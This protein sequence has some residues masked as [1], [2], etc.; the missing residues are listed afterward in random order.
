MPAVFISHHFS[1]VI[2]PSILQRL[3]RLMAGSTSPPIAR[4]LGLLMSSITIKVTAYL[5]IW[6]LEVDLSR[7]NE[8]DGV[9]GVEEWSFPR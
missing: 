7:S 2:Y 6:K 9:G 1:W 5:S 8:D 4:L 3:V